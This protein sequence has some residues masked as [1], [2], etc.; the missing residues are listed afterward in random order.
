MRA[1]AGAPELSQTLRYKKKMT[2][3]TLP[4]P[5]PAT[6]RPV[7]AAAGPAQE[8]EVGYCMMTF[9]IRNGLKALQL[10]QSTYMNY[11]G[12]LAKSWA[13]PQQ[14]EAQVCVHGMEPA[15]VLILV[16]LVFSSM[17]SR[18]QMLL[19]I[20]RCI[21]AHPRPSVSS[22]DSSQMHAF[23]RAWVTWIGTHGGV[24]SVTSSNYLDKAE[25]FVREFL[26]GGGSMLSSAD[27][28][29]SAAEPRPPGAFQVRRRRR[30]E[31][32]AGWVPAPN[33]GRRAGSM[34]VLAQ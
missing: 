28:P 29:G 26:D 8:G 13:L 25:L 19:P 3:W 16:L 4:S 30:E 27:A 18:S 21:P 6:G 5:S 14:M 15:C 31:G 10:G 11:V 12:S 9:V 23:A 22:H 32:G 7:A 2:M 24:A 33:A 20:M 17:L 34:R 1:L